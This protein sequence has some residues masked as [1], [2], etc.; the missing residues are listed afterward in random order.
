MNRCV[1]LTVNE[2]REQTRLIHERQRERQTLE[3]LMARKEKEHILK[4]H[5]N[6]QRLLRPLLVANPYARQ[7]KFL[8]TST[9]TRR[10]HMKYL[11]LIRAIA[12]LHQHQ[13][14]VKT[15]T[16][17]GEAVEYIEVEPRDIET[18]NRLCHQVLG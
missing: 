11:T 8:D 16:H 15:T 4:L 6:A 9:R 5:Q 3:G 1:V 14:A 13:R 17:R 12:L 10:D 2:E 18:A 7:L